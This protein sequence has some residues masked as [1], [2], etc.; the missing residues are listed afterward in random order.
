MSRPTVARTYDALLGGKDNFE[1]DRQAAVEVEKLNP[2]TMQL[3]Q[4]N[5]AFLVRG[6]DHVTASGVRQFIDLGSGLPAADN[7][8]QVAQR[9]APGASVVY[10][11]IDPI[12]L[13]HGRAI[14]ADSPNTTVTTADLRDV[15]RV[16]ESPDTQRLIDFAQPVC[17][18]FVSLL[19]CIP[20]EDD[21]FGLVDRYFER[22]APGSAVIFSHL[23]S[24]DQTAAQQ[25]TERIH[26]L[27]MEWGRVRFPEEIAHAFDSLEIVS[28]STDGSA[29]P[30]L[31]D[32]ATWRNGSTVPEK[33]PA[34][35]D[36]KIW[37]HAAVGF[38]R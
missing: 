32:C 38:K 19:H 25:L 15:D 17:V 22:L 35:P 24:D 9:S 20:D 14:L 29:P 37:E 31:V 23:A 13:A 10:V 12:V 7:T 30:A 26:S 8:H 2:G 18:M 36:K 4:D 28:P 6:V 3:V 5:R 27:G 34:D 21:P 1:V 33:R 16:L 11:D